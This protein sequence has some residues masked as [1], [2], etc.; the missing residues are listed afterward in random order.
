MAEEAE[1]VEKMEGEVEEVREE[2]K[3]QRPPAPEGI[4]KNQWKKTCKKQRYRAEKEEMKEKIRSVKAKHERGDPLDAMETLLFQKAQRDAH[5]KQI[6]KRNKAHRSTNK[7]LL[8]SSSSSSSIDSSSSSSSSS[9]IDSSTKSSCSPALSSALVVCFDCGFDDKMALRETGSMIAQLATCYSLL[10]RFPL[11]ALLFFTGLSPSSLDRLSRCSAHRWS[12][13]LLSPSPYHALFIPSSIDSSASTI[14]SSSSSTTTTTSISSS[15]DSSVDASV[16]ASVDS[17][18]DSSSSSTS[19]QSPTHASTISELPPHL[20]L[21]SKRQVI[22]LSSEATEVLHD[23]D[24]ENYIYVI[25]GF[26][27]HNRHKG[28]THR[29]ATERGIRTAQLPIGDYIQI[30][31]RKVLTINH[32][33]EILLE[34]YRGLSWQEAFLKVLPQRKRISALPSTSSSS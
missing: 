5:K 33:F 2:R 9:S 17:S 20:Q 28:L 34:K 31:T 29:L 27:D 21:L 6:K 11:P 16:D 32:V 8:L 14:T 4:S 23:L 10:A 18:V 30:E 12:N 22:Y 15:V 3:R 1:K 19:S 7:P 26:V 25:G 13:V 24:P